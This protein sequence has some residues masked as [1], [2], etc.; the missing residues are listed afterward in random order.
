MLIFLAVI[1][2]IH[3]YFLL[4]SL[5]VIGVTMFYVVATHKQIAKL[6]AVQLNMHRVSQTKWLDALQNLEGLQAHGV[7]QAYSSTLNQCQ[8]ESRLS[9]NITRRLIFQMSQK[10][11]A[12][13]QGSWVI[14][15]ALGTYLIV[16]KQITVGGLIAVSML[17]MRCF[18]PLQKLQNYLIQTHSAQAGFEDLDKFLTTANE[19]VDGQEKL[20]RIQEIELVN[21]SLLKP[22]KAAG[23]KIA[24]DY[25]LQNVSFKLALGDR[26]GVI[27]PNGSGK[28]SLLR[29]LSGQ[30]DLA[31]GEF[32]IN[33]LAKSNYNL[34][35]LGQRIGFA[36]QPP[37]IMQGT[38]RENITLKRPWVSTAQ[39]WEIIEKT[40]L[41]NWVRSHPDGLN[42]NIESQGSNLS[43]GQKQLIS[44]CRA[45]AGQP[46]LILLDEPTVCLDQSAESVLIE[47]L[48]TLPSE[49]TLI[50]T[51]HRL[52][53]LACTNE[54]ALVHE[55]K[56]H[57]I[58][59]KSTVLR[60]ANALQKP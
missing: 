14:T 8:L 26:M 10:L 42:M 13:Q 16:D 49:T 35:E 59:D 51:T 27:G 33:S 28:T 38:L 58:G 36:Q 22:G 19:K 43:A 50:L 56:I 48:K 15:I 18:T 5:S 25:L 17:T 2:F 57:T 37:L 39:C 55:A 9:S 21:A 40:G 24:N 11:Y 52:N 60:A 31:D 7:Q 23:S 54:L 30:Y 12:L 29:L 45:L 3:P 4:I 44:L 6:G 34:S 41:G 20:D 47:I 32:R 1:G 53:L 46:D